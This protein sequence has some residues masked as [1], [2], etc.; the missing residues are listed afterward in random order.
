MYHKK[1]RQQI[2]TP[3]ELAALRKSTGLSA[4]KAAVA[5]GIGHRTMASYEIGEQHAP[6]SVVLLLQV[7]AAKR[8]A[9]MTGKRK[10]MLD[11]INAPFDLS[12]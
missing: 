9:L 5:L 1:P 2:I 3:R 12:L 4:K 11:F 7:L 8:Q 6:K 10:D